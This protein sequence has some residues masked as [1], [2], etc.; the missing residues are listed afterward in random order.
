MKDLC[1]KIRFNIPELDN[2]LPQFEKNEAVNHAHLIINNESEKTIELK[3]YFDDKCYLD[4]KICRWLDKQEDSSKLIEVIEI[5]AINNEKKLEKIDLSESKWL[6]IKTGSNLYEN[7]VKYFTLT[8]DSVKFIYSPVETDKNSDDWY[9]SE[10]YLN[11]ASEKIFESLYSFKGFINNENS[12]TPIKRIKEPIL[13]G[14]VKIILD[15]NFLSKKNK[16]ENTHTIY[17]E[18][19]IKVLHLD[20]SEDELLN[21]VKILLGIL[22]LHRGEKIDFELGRIHTSKDTIVLSKIVKTSLLESRGGLR[23]IGYYKGI[24][25]LLEEINPKLII[26][27]ANL[28]SKFCW[29]YVDALKLK[30]ESRFMIFYNLLEQIRNLY[31]DPKKLKQEYTF[32]EGKNKVNKKIKA[33]LQELAELVVEEERVEFK[34]NV[35]NHYSSIRYIPMKN[36][37]EGLFNLFQLNLLYKQIDFG[38]IMKIRNK[39]FHGH[40]TDTKDES[41]KEINQKLPKL[42][43]TFLLKISGVN[44]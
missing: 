33:K 40:I 11:K 16:D 13:F 38:K 17:Q 8:L 23:A 4:D 9:S 3:T 18:P 41:F 10:F 34:E 39:I 12:W 43:S 5:L 32:I 6:E 20:K 25:K 28:Y 26:E 37:F 19:R 21:Y 35:K 27:N 30:D 36:Q 42:V 2:L 22:T 14:E 7:N 44:I 29:R 31:L 15:Y 24:S 1:L